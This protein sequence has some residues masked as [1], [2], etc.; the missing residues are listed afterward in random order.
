MLIRSQA[1]IEADPLAPP[2]RTVEADAL[3]LPFADGAFAAA[4]NAFGLR[5]LEDP[6]RGLREMLRILQP[7]GAVV[8]LEFSKP[9]NPLL[10]PLFGF[11]F[12][13]VLPRL[14]AWISG[15]SFAY[16]YLP[17]SVRKFPS[18]D[19]LA[20]M[21]RQAGFADVG[22]RNLSGGIAALHWG[23]RPVALR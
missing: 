21:M 11:Y 17:D 8:I 9:V 19:E 13:H 6:Q 14:G 4:T 3:S 15:Q 23:R 10:R 1:K 5:N 16:T 22:Y 12:R 2:I 20:A 7:A 18:Q